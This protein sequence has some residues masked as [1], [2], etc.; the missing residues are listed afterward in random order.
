MKKYLVIVPIAVM[1]ASACK[2]RSGDTIE[3]KFNLPKGSNY[4]YSSE[5]AMDVKQNLIQQEVNMKSSMGFSYLLQVINDSAN[6]KTLSAT[7]SKI[8]MAMDGMGNSVR[9][10]TETNTD[11]AGP[12]GMMS[13]VF[14]VIK[15]SQ[16]SFT[17]NERGEIGEIRGVKEMQQRMLRGIGMPESAELMEGMAK[18][19][20]DESIRENMQQAF[21]A[22]PGKP[23]KLGESWTKVMVQK[24]Q[25]MNVKMNNTYTLESVNGNDVV[26]KQ[27][28]NLSPEGSGSLDGALVNLTGTSDGKLH[29]D[30]TT[31][32]VTT[33]NV[34]MNM[35]MKIKNG[36]TEIPMTMGMKI[37]TKGKKM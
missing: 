21:A 31:G 14:G 32:M 11:T 33:G 28:S 27:V 30:L 12:M 36:N 17:L 15:G 8:S 1:A 22:Y 25:G 24:A 10:N 23:V 4:E 6:W 7:I 5:V 37:I 26:I 13:K 20:D 34:D 16:F 35:D 18:N 19:F 3:L 29:Y 9:F 2:N